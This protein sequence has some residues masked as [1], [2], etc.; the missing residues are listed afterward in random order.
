MKFVIAL[1]MTTPAFS[2]IVIGIS[3]YWCR[4]YWIWGLCF[5]SLC[6]IFTLR[7]FNQSPNSQIHVTPTQQFIS[8]GLKSWVVSF[9]GLA[10]VNFTP[11]CLG[12]DN[13]DGN[14]NVSDCILLTV[15]W[16]F[17]NSILVVPAILIASFISHRVLKHWVDR[18][19]VR[20]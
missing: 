18:I 6:F 4:I 1:I 17:F 14:N 20:R 3:E 19:N 7:L 8:G 2:L 15:I 12:Q 13:G 16:P 9:A 10:I 5:A 11:L